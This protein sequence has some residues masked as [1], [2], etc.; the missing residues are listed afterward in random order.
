MKFK[1]HG[2]KRSSR[3]CNLPKATLTDIFVQKP[4]ENKERSDLLPVLN[5]ERP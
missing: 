1:G 2:K 3:T 5:P 4:R